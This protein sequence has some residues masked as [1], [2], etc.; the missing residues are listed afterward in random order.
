MTLERTLEVGLGARS[1]P[2]PHRPRHPRRRRRA[3][4]GLGVR[5]AVDRHQSDTV[6]AHWLDRVQG[7]LAASGVR[8]DVVLVPD[9]EA[10]KN[11]ATLEAVVTR[12]LE[13]RAE[14]KTI[15]VALGGGVVGDIGGFAAAVYQR[16]M[17]FVQIPTTLLVAGRLVGRRQDGHQ[18]SAGQ[19]HGGRVLP[20]ARR[21]DRHRLPRDAAG[22]R[23][24][25]GPRGGDQVRRD[26]R[27]RASSRGSRRTS[28]RWRRAIRMR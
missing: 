17:P 10:H 6:A 24:R 27:C 28:T 13:L 7:V 14:R 5:A 23:A 15:L 1:Y 26:P 12:L 22:A 25:G 8:S 9:G 4:A 19:E 18:P 11:F 2:D 16:G 20:A 3:L 21:A